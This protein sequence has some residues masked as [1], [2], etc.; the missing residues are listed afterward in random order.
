MTRYTK[1]TVI[2]KLKELNYKI[3]NEDTYLQDETATTNYRTEIQCLTHD[4]IYLL[5]KKHKHKI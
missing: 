4:Y 3:V 1:D 2:N 5:Y